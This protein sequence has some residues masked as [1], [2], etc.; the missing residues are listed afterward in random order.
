MLPSKRT[1][2][3][4]IA[5]ETTDLVRLRRWALERF[6]VRGKRDVVADESWLADI[7]EDTW[8]MFFI[9]ER[10]ASPLLASVMSTDGTLKIP[11]GV[12]GFLREEA[13][14]DT[15]SVL[16][17]ERDGRWIAT[18][19]RSVGAK[20]IALKGLLP[21]LAGTIPPLHLF[22]V[23]I[24]TSAEDASLLAPK[25][26]SA[27][28]TA[29]TD[30]ELHHVYWA[31]PP[32]H[33]PIEIH[34][35]IFA[36]GSPIP[37][38]ML[39]RVTEIAGVPGMYRLAYADQMLHVLRHALVQHKE[40]HIRIRDLLLMSWLMGQMSEDDRRELD[41]QLDKLADAASFRRLLKF[42]ATLGEE[43]TDSESPVADPFEDDA[44]LIFAAT[45]LERNSA[46]WKGGP[47]L[48]W[49]GA[50]SV[51]AGRTS[52]AALTRFAGRNPVTGIETFAVLQ[53]K[54]PGAGRVVTRFGRAL[55]YFT[56]ATFCSPLL[57]TMRRDVK[58][59]LTV[60]SSSR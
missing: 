60:P 10:C 34:E 14:R 45:L 6:R 4:S 17:A 57:L 52:V 12:L 35:T 28:F 13:A 25:L 44:I 15:G 51:A 31:P 26:E 27:G 20:P 50:A 40:R 21:A 39:S 30:N 32:G 5:G 8:R 29:A 9:L 3:R 16:R 43:R 33:L 22:D 23:D 2:P 48:A 47:P 55:L 49:H 36:D 37:D 54:T 7:P 24:L 38:D 59:R 42:A 56:S 1:K 53:R 46:L 58:R 11:A 18:A 19:A 41:C